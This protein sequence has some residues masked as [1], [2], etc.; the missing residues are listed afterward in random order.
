VGKS[1]FDHVRPD[2]LERGRRTFAEVWSQPG[3]H[4]PFELRVP[5]KDGS[6]RHCE[7]LLNNLLDDPSVGAW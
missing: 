6:W 7:F 3:V 1:V 2:D 4:P 5:H